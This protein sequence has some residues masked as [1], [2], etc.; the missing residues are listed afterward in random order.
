MFS[1]VSVCPW[2]GGICH[3]LGLEADTPL[4]RHTPGR[5]TP[6]CMGY[7]QQ[8]YASPWNV[9][10]LSMILCKNKKKHEQECIPVGCVPRASVGRVCPGWGEGKRL[11]RDGVCQGGCL[12]NGMCLTSEQND[13]QTGVK[14]Y[15]PATSFAGG[16]NCSWKP[17]VRRVFVQSELVVSG[18]QTKSHHAIAVAKMEIFFDVYLFLFSLW[19][20][21]PFRVNG[22]YSTHTL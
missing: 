5:H 20:S 4:V 19:F 2:G 6:Q 14:H 13:W 21:P 9:F 16:K 1:P 11:P 7:G 18:T 10:L 8:A 12:C 15:L 17:S 3:P 22:P